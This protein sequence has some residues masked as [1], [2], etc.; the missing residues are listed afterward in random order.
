MKSWASHCNQFFSIFKYISGETCQTCYHQ[1]AKFRNFLSAVIKFFFLL[2]FTCWWSHHFWNKLWNL[3]RSIVFN[4]EFIL[5]H[6]I[7]TMNTFL[8]EE[9][10]YKR[11]SNQIFTATCFSGD[12]IGDIYLDLI[13]S[14]RE[15]TTAL[16]LHRGTITKRNITPSLHE[17][18]IWW[19]PLSKTTNQILWL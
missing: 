3:I 10:P 7:W 4:Q 13:P 12:A 2:T 15:K 14:L 5:L 18:K 9:P 17:N 6:A 8:I 19:W 16:I 1:T 11:I